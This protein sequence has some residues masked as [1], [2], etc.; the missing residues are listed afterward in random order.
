LNCDVIARTAEAGKKLLALGG[1]ACLC[2]DHDLGEGESGYDVTKWA[3]ENRFMSDK[4]LIVSSNPVGRDNI[5]RL[6]INSGYKR[7]GVNFVK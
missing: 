4:V 1:W 3:I 5:A 2:L 7:R 6:L